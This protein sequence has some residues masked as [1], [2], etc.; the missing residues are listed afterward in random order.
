[1]PVDILAWP[2]TGPWCKISEAMDYVLS[3]KPRVAFPV[4]DGNLVRHGITNRLPNLFLP[5][6]GIQ[7]V[8]LELNK[9]SDL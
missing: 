9:E 6:A 3:V 7:F 4:H 8:A 5:P 2:I 1:V